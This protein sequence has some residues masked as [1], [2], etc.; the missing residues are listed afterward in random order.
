MDDD[1]DHNQDFQNDHDDIDGIQPN[2]GDATVGALVAYEGDDIA[3]PEGAHQDAN[4]P[5]TRHTI[6]NADSS[7]FRHPRSRWSERPMW[8]IPMINE[9]RRQVKTDVTQCHHAA[10]RRNARQTGRFSSFDQINFSSH[11]GAKSFGTRRLNIG[12][13][14]RYEFNAL[15]W[16]TSLSLLAGKMNDTNGD[17]SHNFA[18]MEVYQ[19]QSDLTMYK[20][21]TL[22]LVSKTAAEDNPNFGQSM[23]GPNAEGL[24]DACAWEISTLQKLCSRTQQVI[25]E[26]G[27][28]L[29]LQDQ[30]VP[31]WADPE[32]E[33]PLL[34][35]R[36]HDADGRSRLLQ[37]FC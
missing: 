31:I 16:G 6:S 29:G 37:Y 12:H 1:G 3:P 17:S 4:T 10:A 15:N 8:P 5:I 19:D 24:W 13:I 9:G 34:Y 23:N 27:I 22:G 18:S 28:Y 30:A 35:E 32:T 36:R 14:N 7:V 26:E 33:G 2:E 21:Q 11:E 25:C 20:F